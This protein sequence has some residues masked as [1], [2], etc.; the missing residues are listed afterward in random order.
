[1]EGKWHFETNLMYEYAGNYYMRNGSKHIAALLLEKAITGYRHGGYYGK[2]RQ[3][4][5]LLYPNYHHHNNNENDVKEQHQQQQEENY[6]GHFDHFDQN[7]FYYYN[8]PKSRSVCIQTDNIMTPSSST[9][10]NRDSI[11]DFSLT[12]QYLHTDIPNHETTPEET[13]MA[14]DVVDLASILKSSR[15]ISSE[16]NFELLM[17]QMLQVYI[18]ING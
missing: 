6:F 7:N 16:M 12:E 15:V 1:M 17:K 9:I 8:R 18:Y 4:K 10:P 3:L 5:H 13:L 11:S 14:L 2:E